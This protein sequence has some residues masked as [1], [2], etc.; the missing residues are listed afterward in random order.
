MTAYF[1]SHVLETAIHGLDAVVLVNG[2]P[3]A[4]SARPGIM[5]TD[6][7][8]VNSM[9][10]EGTNVLS[11]L[12]KPLGETVPTDAMLDV[13]LFHMLGPD[14][15]TTIFRHNWR[16]A[17]RTLKQDEYV[18]VAR[19]E[20]SFVDT[21]GRYRWE[22]ARPFMLEDQPALLEA[23]KKLMLTLERRDID[24]YVTLS[25]LKLEE[26]ARATG[27]HPQQ[28]IDESSDTLKSFAAL[29]GGWMVVPVKD[30][31]L[32]FESYS[33]GR[34]VEVFRDGDRA[35]PIQVLCGGKGPMAFNVVFSR[36]DERWVPVR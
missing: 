9:V 1:P 14:Q 15:R 5:K 29:E 26:V 33:G 18:E 2:W 31:D 4:R 22:D 16:L 12:A 8:R 20:V 13:H 36:V 35:P 3:A 10:I 30:E 17:H 23:F 7:V 6:G 19:H 28:A 25:T 34:L 27:R 11:V 24:S 21:F 32:Q